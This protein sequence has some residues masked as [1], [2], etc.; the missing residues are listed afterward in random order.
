MGNRFFR[1]KL[2]SQCQLVL[3]HRDASGYILEHSWIAVTL[4][5]GLSL[6]LIEHDVILT[7][8]N[9]PEVLNDLT[10]DATTNENNFFLERN[11]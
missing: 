8:E 4:D 3:N 10:L 9:K 5:H 2:K 6:D 11:Y 7:K 1:V